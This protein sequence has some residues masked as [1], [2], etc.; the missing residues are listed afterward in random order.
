MDAWQNKTRRLEA[1]EDEFK[2]SPVFKTNAWTML[3]IG[4]AKEYFDI[5]EADHDTTDAAKSYEELLSKVQDYAKRR[6]LDSSAQ[7]ELQHAGYC[8]C[9]SWGRLE[10]V[11]RQWRRTRS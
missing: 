9:W 2:L 6:K 5:W 10:L 3:I 4:A 7:D 1:H 11:G 8:G